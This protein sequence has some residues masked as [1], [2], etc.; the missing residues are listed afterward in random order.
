MFWNFSS[1]AATYIVLNHL[2]YIKSYLIITKQ[3]G[4]VTMLP[5]Q[6][7]RASKHCPDNNKYKTWSSESN[8]SFL[9]VF[10]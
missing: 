4:K 8:S 5:T 1:A 7:W 9:F 2:L 6:P 10:V 3:I